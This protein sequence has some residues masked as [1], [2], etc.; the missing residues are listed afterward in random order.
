M[1]DT[2]VDNQEF[3]HQLRQLRENRETGGRK[4]KATSFHTFGLNDDLFTPKFEQAKNHRDFKVMI[5][6]IDDDINQKEVQREMIQRQ[7]SLK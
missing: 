3:E 5:K 6:H 4:Q 7:Q 2:Q 1:T